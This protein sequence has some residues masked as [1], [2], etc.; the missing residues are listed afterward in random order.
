[1]PFMLHF[2]CFALSHLK[3][4]FKNVRSSDEMTFEHEIHVT[5]KL[6]MIDGW[7]FESETRKES[8]RNKKVT[9]ILEPNKM[10]C[11]LCN[12]T[13]V[14]VKQTLRQSK[15]K[16]QT[17]LGSYKQTSSPTKNG[18]RNVRNI[19]LESKLKSLL[20]SISN[21]QNC[22]HLFK[23]DKFDKISRKLLQ[24]AVVDW[25]AQPLMTNVNKAQFLPRISSQL[26]QS[27]LN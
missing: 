14:Y 11:F 26:P 2:L 1:M 5:G 16:V 24:L 12:L 19:C 22:F 13:Q 4:L 21:F 17:T 27:A 20:P 9:M 10:C 7:H 23:Y 25:T 8:F 3:G 18:V 15:C 6:F